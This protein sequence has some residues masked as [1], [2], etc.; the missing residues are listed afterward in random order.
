MLAIDFTVVAAIFRKD[1]RT[2]L[3]NPTGYVFLT[4]FIGVTA[5]A[6]FLQDGFFSRNLA[7]FA[8]LNKAM[9]AILMFFVPAI[10]MTAWSDE[11]RWGTD[12]LLLTLPVRDGEV[13]FGK[14]LG[15]LGMYTVALG[16]SLAHVVV[17]VSL[18]SPDAGLMLSTYLGY[19]LIGGLFVAIG[20]LGSMFT[21]NPTVG[22]ILGA[23][24]CASLVVAG[25]EPWAGGIL[26]TMTLGLLAALVWLVVRGELRGVGVAGSAGAVLAIVLWLVGAR[27]PG[28]GSQ[29]F[30]FAYQFGRLG[31]AEHF[32]SFGEGVIRL[33]D[34]FYFVGGTAL[35]LYLCGFLLGRRHW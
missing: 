14:Y 34:L 31:V 11:R 22:F 18:G 9:P 2:Y 12:E 13:I 17:L 35:V 10:T 20:L 15:A 1:I 27:L 21:P 25:S 26:G 4:L 29:G 3:A 30:D 23:L 32:A 5:A 28:D 6:A 33:G 8:L 7:D 19:W 16:F 24:G